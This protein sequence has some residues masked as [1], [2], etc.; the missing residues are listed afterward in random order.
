MPAHN[1]SQ[2]LL[3]YHFLL[4]SPWQV[5]RPHREHFPEVEGVRQKRRGCQLPRF[6]SFEWEFTAS[7]TTRNLHTENWL[8]HLQRGGI[9]IQASMQENG[10]ETIQIPLNMQYVMICHDSTRQKKKD[11]RKIANSR[12]ITWNRRPKCHQCPHQGH[13]PGRKLH[14]AIFHVRDLKADL[15]EIVKCKKRWKTAKTSWSLKKHSTRKHWSVHPVAPS[16]FEGSSAAAEHR[17]QP[18]WN[19]SSIFAYPYLSRAYWC[20]NQWKL[21]DKASG[22]VFLRAGSIRCLQSF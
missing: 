14:F 22:F 5:V 19:K 7:E 1:A 21:L 20:L 6:E 11:K 15:E 12:R 17:R 13:G 18:V 9:E 8:H 3:A 4:Q 10:R 16:A 2:I